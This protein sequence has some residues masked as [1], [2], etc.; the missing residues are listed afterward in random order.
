[1]LR[2]LILNGR[3]TARLLQCN[4]GLFIP[5]PD[6]SSRRAAAK[7]ARFFER[8]KNGRLLKM[9]HRVSWQARRGSCELWHK[10][11]RNAAKSRSTYSFEE[12][13]L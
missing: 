8:D 6:S 13:V 10:S 9:I 7:T 1:M 3:R 5:D 4:D 11:A 2:M 12:W